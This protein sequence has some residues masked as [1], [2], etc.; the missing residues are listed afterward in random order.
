M[1]EYLNEP[2]EPVKLP[3]GSIE[4]FMPRIDGKTFRCACG[5]NVFHKPDRK[6]PEV[7]Q[8]NGCDVRYVGRLKSNGD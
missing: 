5:C 3:D 1:Y 4:N 2:M 7:Y 8:C 6:R